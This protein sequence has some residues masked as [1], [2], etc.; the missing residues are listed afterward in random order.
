MEELDESLIKRVQDG[1]VSAFKTIVKRY[2]RPLFSFVFRIMHDEH[3][4]ED[5][6]QETFFKIYKAIDR[7]DI[8][9]KFS[10]FA[11]EVAKNSA[12]SYLRKIKK[13]VSINDI[14]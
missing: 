5:V 14:D 1:D 8:N 6:V 10:T 9:R 13:Q 4:S 3:V 2:Q 12:I 7:I 11:F